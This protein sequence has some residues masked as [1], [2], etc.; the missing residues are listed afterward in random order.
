MNQ[1]LRPPSSVGRV[2]SMRVDEGRK[3]SSLFATKMNAH[4]SAG[5][6]IGGGEEKSVL[7]RPGSEIRLQT[8]K[9]KAQ[10]RRTSH[11]QTG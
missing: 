2:N 10:L 4:T 11:S 3:G 9:E 5:V 8:E 6:G 7:S 1:M